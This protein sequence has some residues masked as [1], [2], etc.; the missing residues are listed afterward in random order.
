[1]NVQFDYSYTFIHFTP[2]V[3]N[4]WS[5]CTDKTQKHSGLHMS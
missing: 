2:K 4:D 1:M 5:V 3:K